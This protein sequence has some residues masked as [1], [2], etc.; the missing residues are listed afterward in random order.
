MRL[1][2]SCAAHF[3][4]DASRATLQISLLAV[5]ADQ[6]RAHLLYVVDVVL[7]TKEENACCKTNDRKYYKGLTVGNKKY[8]LWIYMDA[9]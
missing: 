7:I 6:S 1:M 8:N 5:V 2:P 9:V 3:K 4:I